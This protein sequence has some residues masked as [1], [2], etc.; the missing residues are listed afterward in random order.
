MTKNWMIALIAL[1]IMCDANAYA[2]KKWTKYDSIAYQESQ[3]NKKEDD[4]ELEKREAEERFLKLEKQLQEKDQQISELKE[5]IQKLPKRRGRRRYIHKKVE[6]KN[7]STQTDS[8]IGV[9][10]RPEKASVGTQTS[11]NVRGKIRY[12]RRNRNI[13]LENPRL[14]I[15]PNEIAT[16]TD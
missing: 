6:M 1:G 14:N 11:N 3:K 5:Q 15:G 13:R 2:V 7:A 16:Q 12:A 4:K 10:V 9:T 8:K